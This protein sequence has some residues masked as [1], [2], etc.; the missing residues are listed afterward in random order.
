MLSLNGGWWKIVAFW[1][2]MQYSLVDEYQRLKGA[3][4]LR[5]LGSKFPLMHWYLSTK[6]DT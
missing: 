1:D 2:Q 5:V 6:L 3:Y 4:R